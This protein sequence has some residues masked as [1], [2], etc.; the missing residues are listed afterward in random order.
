MTPHESHS[1]G[2]KRGDD[3]KTFGRDCTPPLP[4]PLYSSVTSITEINFDKGAL[5]WVVSASTNTPCKF[6]WW[7][8]LGLPSLSH[9]LNTIC[10]NGVMVAPKGIVGRHVCNIFRTIPFH[11]VLVAIFTRMFILT[12][13]QMRPP[14][15][16]VPCARQHSIYS[17]IS[18][19]L[20]SPVLKS[21]KSR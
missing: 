9:Q 13:Q 11:A 16:E 8:V 7:T 14:A 15:A 6:E 10:T 18:L 2:R 17:G 20:H 19:C 3:G 21:L 4:S 1:W 12:C 5:G